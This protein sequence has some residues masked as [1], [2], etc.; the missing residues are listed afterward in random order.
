MCT[1]NCIFILLVWYGSNVAPV[2]DAQ[3]SIV[4][5]EQR[6]EQQRAERGK[7]QAEAIG[8]FLLAS[9]GTKK[10]E[11]DDHF[12][13]YLSQEEVKKIR[14]LKTRKK[15]SKGEL[16]GQWWI[17]DIP[18]PGIDPYVERERSDGDGNLRIGTALT[19]RED[20]YNLCFIAQVKQMYTQHCD[21][22]G[23]E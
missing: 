3:A 22:Q 1:V 11:E 16:D 4:E 20:M 23:A 2:M 14:K 13:K 5:D 8:L 18:E 21:E 19:F 12:Q 15:P 6:W 10:D 7:I 9:M 17:P